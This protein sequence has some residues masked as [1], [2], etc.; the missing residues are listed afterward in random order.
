L[1][2][3]LNALLT[4]TAWGTWLPGPARG[5]VD[6][7]S[8]Q[9][10]ADLP[11][12]DRRLS[13]RRRHA[14]KWPAARLDDAQRRLVLGDLLRIAQ[15]R[16]FAPLVAVIDEDHAHL[17]ATFAIARDQSPSRL[18][19]LVKGSLSRTLSVAAGDAPPTTTLGAPLPHR[20][21]WSPQYSLRRVPDDD[22]REAVK[23]GLVAHAQQGAS[24]RTTW[25]A[26]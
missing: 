22:A 8:A 3:P 21:W 10:T 23:R 13:A 19:Q 4:W 12:P 15:L 11:E 5:W 6:P 9:R 26:S 1:E 25:D 7:G 24:I 2:A 18:V 20:K 17:L 16:A 14:L